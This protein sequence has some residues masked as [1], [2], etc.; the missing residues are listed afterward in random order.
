L[1]ALVRATCL[2]V[3]VSFACVAPAAAAQT[4]FAEGGG[5]NTTSP[6]TETSAACPASRGRRSKVPTT[7]KP[8]SF[9]IAKVGGRS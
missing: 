9:R 3:M 5:G 7:K 4:F 6:C 8:W 1:K 2:A